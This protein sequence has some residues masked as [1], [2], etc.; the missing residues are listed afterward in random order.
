MKRFKPT[1]KG[2]KVT[3]VLL[4]SALAVGAVGT[5][6]K[7]HGTMGNYGFDLVSWYTLKEWLDTREKLLAI[8]R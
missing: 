1:S 5:I 8:K 2:S 4:L 6:A 7:H 3:L